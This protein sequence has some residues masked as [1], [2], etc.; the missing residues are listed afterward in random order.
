MNEVFAKYDKD[1]SNSLDPKEVFNIVKDYFANLDTSKIVTQ[2]EVDEL[3]K[4]ADKNGDGKIQRK[5]L[6]AL[7]KKILGWFLESTQIFF[8]H[9]FFLSYFWMASSKDP[10]RKVGKNYLKMDCKDISWRKCLVL[11]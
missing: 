3:V 8:I 2:E 9:E 11:F 6:K 1:N 5:E 4:F 7:F 10:W